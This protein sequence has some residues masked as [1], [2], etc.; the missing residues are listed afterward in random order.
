MVGLPTAQMQIKST[1]TNAGWDFVWET[2]NGPNDVW[3]ICDGA[4]YPKLA[5]QF[6]PGD[7]D[8][9]GAVNFVDLSMMLNKWHQFDNPFYCGG[10]KLKS[11]IYWFIDLE[12]LAIFGEHWLQGF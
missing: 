1:F 3:A 4:S 8:N 9:D 10:T 5:W 12:D 11:D 2:A 6:I 7:F